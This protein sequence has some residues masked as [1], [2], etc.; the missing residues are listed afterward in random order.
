[1]LSS[2]SF[3]RG[4]LDGTRRRGKFPPSS[5]ARD[6]SEIRGR[7]LPRAPKSGKC[8]RIFTDLT[9]EANPSA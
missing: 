3:P 9:P 4:R 7:F 6:R 1:M 2:I 5:W 8:S